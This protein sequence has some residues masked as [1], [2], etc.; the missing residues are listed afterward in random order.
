MFF[1]TFNPKYRE[2]LISSDSLKPDNGKVILAG[3]VIGVD[4]HTVQNSFSW[5]KRHDPHAVPNSESK[6]LD[7]HLI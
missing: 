7:F 5:P 6:I 2:G 4:A 3:V 1:F